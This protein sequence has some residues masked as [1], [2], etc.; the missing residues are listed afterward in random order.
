MCR[1]GQTS[2]SSGSCSARNA[3]PHRPPRERPWGWVNRTGHGR[4]A[5]CTGPGTGA[6][7]R[8]ESGAHQYEMR[9]R[10]P[11]PDDRVPSSEEPPHPAAE[12]TGDEHGSSAPAPSQRVGAVAESPLTAHP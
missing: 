8:D 3:I 7:T 11:R 2:A 9:W 5:H 1:C 6:E 4:T 10:S 12:S